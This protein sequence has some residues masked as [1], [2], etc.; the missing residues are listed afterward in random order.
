LTIDQQETKNQGKPRG[1][2]G[3]AWKKGRK[4]V[5]VRAKRKGGN[6]MHRAKPKE[7]AE[8]PRIRRVSRKKACK[9][10]KGKGKAKKTERPTTPAIKTPQQKKHEPGRTGGQRHRA[11]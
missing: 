6:P 1:C 2:A 9:K 7:R 3:V 5:G 11:G 4:T 10:A 8:T